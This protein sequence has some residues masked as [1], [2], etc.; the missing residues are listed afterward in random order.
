MATM[1]S[2][3]MFH[4]VSELR[5]LV[6]QHGGYATMSQWLK[7]TVLVTFDG[8]NDRDRFVRDAT[9]AAFETTVNGNSVLVTKL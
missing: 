2:K 4:R 5:D 9:E 1:Y 7:G 3:Q 6:E 8:R